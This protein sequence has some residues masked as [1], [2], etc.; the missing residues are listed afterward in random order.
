MEEVATHGLAPIR[1]ALDLLGALEPGSWA[2][3]TSGSRA[4]AT[5][6]LRTVG[7]PIPDIMVTGDEVRFGKPH[8]EPY[9]T[10]ADRSGVRPSQCIVVEDAPAGVQSAKSAGMKVLAVTTTHDR[11]ALVAADRVLENLAQVRAYVLASGR[12]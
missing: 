8:P 10:G 9:L 7:L 2:I 11:E 12:P 6:R 4:V 1:G 5:L 3:V